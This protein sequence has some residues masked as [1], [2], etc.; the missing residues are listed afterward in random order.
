MSALIAEI[1]EIIRDFL[2]ERVIPKD[3]PDFNKKSRNL[4][5][6]ILLLYGLG[7]LPPI[8]R[9]SESEYH[10][11]YA[12]EIVRTELLP[13]IPVAWSQLQREVVVQVKSPDRTF[14]QREVAVQ[15]KSPERL[16]MEREIFYE[17]G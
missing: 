9:V 3:I 1:M 6:A 10:Q 16:L 2:K 17:I 15:V 4:M 11:P 8:V 7:G 14:L 13:E 12:G 5:T